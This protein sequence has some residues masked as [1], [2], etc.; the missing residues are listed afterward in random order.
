MR[1]LQYFRLDHKLKQNVHF[2]GYWWLITEKNHT[3]WNQLLITLQSQL[4]NY[5]FKIYLK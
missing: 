5:V 4:K 3:G 1:Q 2:I